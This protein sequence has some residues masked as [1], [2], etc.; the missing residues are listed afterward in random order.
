MRRLEDQRLAQEA[1]HK[2]ELA[3]RR[4]KQL[5]NNKEREMARQRKQ[6]LEIEKAKHDVEMQGLEGRRLESEN[7]NI[8]F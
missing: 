8:Q 5:A 1:Q 6:Q 7:E 2:A 4:A 3:R